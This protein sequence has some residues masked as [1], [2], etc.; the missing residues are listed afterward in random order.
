M[1]TITITKNANDGH[2]YKATGTYGLDGYNFTITKNGHILRV[3]GATLG[4]E[5]VKK[6]KEV[7][8]AKHLRDS[9][10]QFLKK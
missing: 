3:G 7:T 2:E 8:I 4:L 9:L 5:A 1:T 6:D 10:N